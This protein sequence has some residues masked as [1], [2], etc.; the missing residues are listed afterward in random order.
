MNHPEGMALTCLI[1]DDSATFLSAS[2]RLLETEGIA[3]VGHASTA[4]EA[5]ARAAETRPDVA[6]VDVDLGD[7]D[8]FAVAELLTSL[9]AA[10]I[11]ISGDAPDGLRDR[12]DESSALGF[13]AKIDLSAR[14]IEKLLRS[15]R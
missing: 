11:L 9:A 10:I 13:I 1:V 4:R 12:I 7:D 8:G 5:V 3:V 6:L 14:E 15:R 2:T